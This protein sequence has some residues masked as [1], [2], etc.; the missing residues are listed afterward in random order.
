L[1]TIF[2]S[3]T[4]LSHGEYCPRAATSHLREYDGLSVLP[5]LCSQTRSVFSAFFRKGQ[6]FET[7]RGRGIF[8]PAVDGAIRQLD[9][10]GWVHL[11]GEGKVNQPSTY[12]ITD[13]VAHLPRFK[14]GVGRILMEAKEP[15]IIVPMW[16]T[17]FDKLMPEGRKAPFKFL[18]KLNVELG[19]AFGEPLHHEEIAVIAAH[20]RS[21]ELALGQPL[22]LETNER[23]LARSNITTVVQQSV[24]RLGRKVSGHL[25]DRPR[26]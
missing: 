24:E 1:R 10:G 5:T 23:K 4:T 7:F 18:P 22:S 6:V 17:G 8:Q 21:A 16:L 11:F 26:T 3:W 19:V 15:P 12:P 13:G 20:K 2:L 25:L 9:S 14:W